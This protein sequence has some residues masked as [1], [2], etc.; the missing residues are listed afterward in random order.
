[1]TM[2]GAA[3]P[4]VRWGLALAAGVAALAIFALAVSAH[5]RSACVEQD[6]P[7]LPLCGDPP[8]PQELRQELRERIARNP[9]DS[10][11]WTQLLVSESPDDADAIL[12]GAV[13]VAP[14]NHNV[15]RW[16]AAQALRDGKIDDAV[17]MLVQILSH[18]SSPEA[19]K[20]VAQLAAGPQG[21]ALLR[22][23]LATAAEWLPQVLAASAA[24]KQ[25]ASDLLPLVAAAVDKGALPAGARQSY[26]RTLKG[27]GQWLD[28]YGLWL[29]A[30]KDAVPLLYNA[31]FD[32]PFE[33]DGFDWEFANDG[34]RSRAGTVLD[35]DAIAR[36]GLVLDVEFTGRRFST[37]IVRQFVFL[38]PGAY[39]VRGEYMAPK[40]RSEQGLA[41][42]IQC[43]AGSRPVVATSP[44]LRET[45][46]VWK[47]VEFEFTIPPDCGAMASLQLDPVGAY[48]AATGMKGH[49]AFDNFSLSHVAVSP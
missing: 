39:R 27:A 37:P 36:R 11:A 29:S 33:V 9:G 45:G 35:Q 8:P 41:W 49:V 21:L 43:T 7:Y 15:A 14:N 5:L 1:M 25:P 34:P 4:K 13:L 19:A 46:G 2:D 3:A 23:H 22:P 17:G 10:T 31:G 38:A 40:L 42:R 26:M 6:T 24:L 30:H 18:R 20:V 28:A 44:P 16:R 12:P 48:E 47:V 32:Q